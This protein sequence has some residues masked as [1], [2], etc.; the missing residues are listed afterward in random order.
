MSANKKS[1]ALVSDKDGVKK[2]WWNKKKIVALSI[3]AVA[4]LAAIIASIV[5]LATTVFPIPSTAEESAVVGRFE[6]NAV[7]YDVKYEELRYVTLLNKRILDN[8]LGEYNDL[9]ALE[10]IEYEKLLKER[11]MED[12]KS[13]VTI[14]ALCDEYG[15]RTDSLILRMRVQQD[16]QDFVNETFGGDAKKYEEW[17]KEEGLTDSLL[18]YVYRVDRLER[19]LLEHFVDNKIDVKYDEND[20]S[21]F[22]DYVMESGDWVRT[23][24]AYFPKNW[25]YAPGDYDPEARAEA[26]CESVL[27]ASGNDDRFE[28]MRKAIGKAPVVAGYV[29]MNQDGVY[30]TYGQMVDAYEKAAF[31]LE[32]YGVSYVVET[33]DGYYVI[34]RLPLEKDYVLEHD[35]ELL[36]QYQYVPLKLRE[37]V[38]RAEIV[39]VGNDGFASIDLLDIE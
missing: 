35:T 39:F 31:A 11:V 38:V 19:Q 30:F 26:A 37:D 32:E 12:I 14:L 29:V 21:G 13:N 9:N 6:Y 20:L 28:A 7:S 36:A 2:K 22:V 16:I 15:I 34:M 5:V 17:L 33:I 8:E 18:R 24:H 23:V 10:R 4:A 27:A 25:E 1:K 3:L